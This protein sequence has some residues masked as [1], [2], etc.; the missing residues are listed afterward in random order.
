MLQIASSLL[1]LSQHSLQDP[2]LISEHP[3]D[4]RTDSLFFVFGIFRINRYDP[5]EM[6]SCHQTDHP[7]VYERLDDL[8]N[9]RIVYCT[10][11][12]R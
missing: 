9:I 11:L 4:V 3:N 12:S 8:K 6:F 7:C 1:R 2:S 10:W 5:L